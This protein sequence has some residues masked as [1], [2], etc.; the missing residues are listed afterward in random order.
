MTVLF[1]AS[2]PVDIP[3]LRLDA[4]SR[5]IHEMIRKSDYRDN[6]RFETRWAVRTSDILQ[7]INEV[8]PD[9][10]HFSGHG[11]SGGDLAF[12]NANGAG[13]LNAIINPV[14]NIVDQIAEKPFEY[15]LTLLPSLS[16]FIASDGIRIFVSN[17]L[18]PALSLV[19]LAEPV[20]GPLL[21]ED[22]HGV[23]L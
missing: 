11:S 16:Y 7:A 5:A 17:L 13:V 3:S 20:I 22:D 12:E 1:L 14:L 23:G 21:D 10:I 9:V 19:E 6:I 2:N 15:I 8:N 18:A 4:E